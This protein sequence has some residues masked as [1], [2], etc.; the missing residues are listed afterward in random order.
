[1]SSTPLEKLAHKQWE[2]AYLES[3]SDFDAV[4]RNVY[5]IL[6]RKRL[7]IYEA[8]GGGSS[9][10]VVNTYHLNFDGLDDNILIS[11]SSSLND[12]PLNDFTVELA[13]VIPNSDNGEVISKIDANSQ[14]WDIYTYQGEMTFL[15]IFNN[16]NS[17][18]FIG[19][20]LADNEI[21]HWEVVWI[22]D[23]ATAKIFR[24]GIEMVYSTPIYIFPENTVQFLSDL[25][26][27]YTDALMNLGIGVA[28]T[29]A[30]SNIAIKV[31]WLRFSNIARHTSNFTP[32]SLVICPP[33]DANTILRLAFDEGTGTIANDTSGNDN[34]GVITGA[35]WEKD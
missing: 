14:G 31:N 28:P 33:V 35:T 13:G 30:G 10:A 7:P 23:S 8:V 24:D 17:E 22:H 21:H 16:F 6:H 3:S 18:M 19:C 4:R 2:E 9:P 32:P 5:R 12:L 11:G 15:F 25:D 26:N 34:S 20:I 1:M 27:L 29:I